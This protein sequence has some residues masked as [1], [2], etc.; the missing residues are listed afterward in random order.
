MRQAARGA[1]SYAM[2]YDATA[3]HEPPSR[4]TIHRLVL[5]EGALTTQH[6]PRGPIALVFAR[7]GT[8]ANRKTL[9]NARRIGGAQ[10]TRLYHR[11]R[12]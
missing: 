12:G 4:E 6:G 9:C 10:R 1:W 8:R 11:T 7:S 2:L 5:L 3:A